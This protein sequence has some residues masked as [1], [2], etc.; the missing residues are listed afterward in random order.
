[1]GVIG[2]ERKRL[3]VSGVGLDPVISGPLLPDGVRRTHGC[4]GIVP[5]VS[6]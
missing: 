4:R 6:H 1:M 3:C 5:T 2:G